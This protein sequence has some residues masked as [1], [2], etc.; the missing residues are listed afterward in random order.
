MTIDQLIDDVIAREGGYSDH[1]ADRGGPTRWGITERVARA[2]FVV[3]L[4]VLFFSLYP[5]ALFL[6]SG[7]DVVVFVALV[8]LAF[9]VRFAIQYTIAMACFWLERASAI[10]A[11][12]M[13]VFMFLSGAIAPR[14]LS[15]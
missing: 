4:S 8:I 10:E 12:H 5:R 3:L 7:S 15:P 14:T 2:P 1:P 11:L 9:I 13:L 6:P